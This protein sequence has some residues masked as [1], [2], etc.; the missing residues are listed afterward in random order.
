MGVVIEETK[1]TL[2]GAS[3]TENAGT[4]AG[5]D[6][7]AWTGTGSTVSLDLGELGEDSKVAIEVSEVTDCGFATG[8]EAEESPDGEMLDTRLGAPGTVP[9][10]GGESSVFAG[11]PWYKLVWAGGSTFDAADGATLSDANKGCFS[12]ESSKHKANYETSK[13]IAIKP[14]FGAGIRCR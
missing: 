5:N 1:G 8:E 13:H 10:N 2:E 4:W 6:F 14:V 7:S 12:P 9:A 3:G 11:S